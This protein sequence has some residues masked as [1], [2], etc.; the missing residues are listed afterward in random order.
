MDKNT[1]K[2]LFIVI[3]YIVTLFVLF[4]IKLILGFA[5]ILVSILFAVYSNLSQVYAILGNRR[6]E[7]GDLEGT[8]HWYKK[9]LKLK[10]CKPKTKTSYG[11][12]LLKSKKLEEAD[13]VLREVEK[14]K[15]D[16]KDDS[17]L[18]MTYA[19]VKWK[20]GHIDEAITMLEYVYT[21]YKCTTVYESLGYLYILD[22]RLEKALEFNLE[23]FDYNPDSK[24]TNDNL[25]ETYYYLGDLD[26]ALEVYEKLIPKNPIFPEPYFHYALTLKEKNNPEK[27]LE[28]FEKA[29]T[30]KEVFLSNL[31]HED[32]K[33]EIENIKKPE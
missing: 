32:I 21:N 23:A 6:F 24:V 22:N 11:Y 5:A 12:L 1:K 18:K 29:L 28:M 7:A 13:A 19:L 8:N 27:A 17:Q 3:G 33:K 9:A 31:T 15:L 16:A 30:F 14:L 4:K 20:S 26:K 10:D 25:G 2:V